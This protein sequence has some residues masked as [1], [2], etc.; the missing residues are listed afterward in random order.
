MTSPTFHDSGELA[1]GAGF[2][3]FRSVV[4]GSKNH[5]RS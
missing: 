2:E 4:Y 1:I 3:V 5:R